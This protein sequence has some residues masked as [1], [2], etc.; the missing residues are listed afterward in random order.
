MSYYL[1]GTVI[2]VKATT[3]NVAKELLDSIF[4]SGGLVLSQVTKLIGLA[5]YEVQNWVKRGFLPPPVHKQ[6][7]RNQF[8]RLA[9]INMLRESMQIDKITKLLSFING[10]LDDSSDDLVD[11]SDLYNY[12]VNLIALM[13]EHLP[14]SD[15][16]HTHVH[17]LTENFR[18]PVPGGRRRLAIVLE[19]ML[20]THFSAVLRKRA[21]D[22]IH[23]LD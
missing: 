10:H 22:L 21:D 5:P 17:Y 7:D 16:I 18:E 12:Y 3:P 14:D 11:D 23:T 9:M 13:G 20:Y 15:E 4:L 2:E 8:C 1:P 19:V 6:Y